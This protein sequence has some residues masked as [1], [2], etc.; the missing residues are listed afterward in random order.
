MA[1][2]DY[3]P[4]FS[5]RGLRNGRSG[6]IG[7]ALPD[8]GT[9]YS[10]EIAHN[11][12]EVAHERGWSVQ[13]EETGM[14]PE[15]EHELLSRAR[16]N[17]I[18]G[19]ILNPVVLDKS[20]V[21]VGVSLPPVVLLGEVSQQITDRVW[22]DSVAAAKEMTLT[23][24]RPGR[25]RIAI[26]GDTTAERRSATALLRRQGYQEALDELGIERD[27]TLHIVCRSWTPRGSAEAVRAFL[28]SLE[29][30]DAFVCFSDSLAIGA[31]SVL[32]D[33]G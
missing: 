2:L 10:A 26:V 7:L 25:R 30:P 6:V 1:E 28:D 3:V 31:L 16:A 14:D 24:A 18:D 4:N 22:V 19:L 23:L 29:L 11:V 21:T 27:P 17:L 13:I 15:R 9:P 12:V 5:A 32:G 20:A 33:R 8:L